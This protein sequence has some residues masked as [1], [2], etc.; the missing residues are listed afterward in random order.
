MKYNVKDMVKF[1]PN[2]TTNQI[3]IGEIIEVYMGMNQYKIMYEGSKYCVHEQFIIE[4][5]SKDEVKIVRY[6]LILAEKDLVIKE[7]TDKI[8]KF[9]AQLQAQV[10]VSFKDDEK[11][12][13]LC[14]EKAALE[15]IIKDCH[16]T[17]AD[18]KYKIRKLENEKWV[19]GSDTPFKSQP[20]TNP[21]KRKIPWSVS[22]SG[23]LGIKSC[24]CN[25][26]SS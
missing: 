11:F 16:K 7:L 10:D 22:Q 6:E 20:Y 18:L 13:N 25:V 19:R 8:D 17:I 26:K 1:Y 12:E 9:A 5:A 21:L 3:F 4:K 24:K 15:M 14:K 2:V 23:T